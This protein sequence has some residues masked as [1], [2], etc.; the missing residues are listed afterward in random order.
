MRFTNPHVAKKSCFVDCEDE[1]DSL[2]NLHDVP[3]DYLKGETNE[4]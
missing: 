1:S 3:R 2:I 4:L